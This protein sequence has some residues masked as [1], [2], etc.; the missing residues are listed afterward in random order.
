MIEPINPGGAAVPGIPLT[1]GIK[2]GDFVYVSGQ[3]ATDD[4][5][6]VVIGDF[7][8]EVNGAIDNVIKVVEAAGGTV[9]QIVK[10]TA[11]LSNGAS[12][13]AFNQIYAKRLGSV[14][15]ARTTI[16]T[17]F[18]NPDVRVELEAVAYL[19]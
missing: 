2:A 17:G 18:G 11:F 8:A 14:P 6:K 12:F 4:Q 16:V 19:G 5:G 7:E 13:A 3:V 15:P 10:I 9:D 1:P